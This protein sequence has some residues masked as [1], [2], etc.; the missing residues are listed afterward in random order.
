MQIITSPHRLN[1]LPLPSKIH[2]NLQRIVVDELKEQYDDELSAIW[3]ELGTFL[4]VLDQHA[5][6]E[7]CPPFASQLTY[8][9]TYP[10]MVESLSDG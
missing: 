10:E 4:V 2:H 3:K 8:C 6:I 7:S 9:A 1:S 5:R